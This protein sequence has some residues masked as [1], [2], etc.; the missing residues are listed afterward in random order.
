MA[1]ADA[2]GAGPALDTVKPK[3][4]KQPL[5][6]FWNA[7]RV[8]GLQMTAGGIGG[9]LQGYGTK[10]NGIGQWGQLNQQAD[11]LELSSNMM[12][13]NIGDLTRFSN[14]KISNVRAAG[15]Q[16]KSSQTVELARSG[17]MVSGEGARQIYAE[18]DDKIN[19]A[20]NTMKEVLALK[21]G[22]IEE[23]AALKKS[24]AKSM[25]DSADARL[26]SSLTIGNINMAMGL[27]QTGAGIYGL[28]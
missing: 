28:I 1:Y 8:S 12:L 9:I 23:T 16:T 20:V 26:H 19:T 6:P 15:T 21:K 14:N 22:R 18:T 3:Q 25:R 10:L 24:Q 5:Q 2:A 4:P 27:I 7:D 13:D 11:N 17:V